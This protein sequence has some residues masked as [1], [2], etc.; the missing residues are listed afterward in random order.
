MKHLKH[1]E[2]WKEHFGNRTRL[3]P[4]VLFS[5]N[6]FV[7]SVIRCVCSQPEFQAIYDLMKANNRR[8]ILHK[9][10]RINIQVISVIYIYKKNISVDCKSQKSNASAWGLM[11][12]PKTFF[13]FLLLALFCL[14]FFLCFLF[15][16][17]FLLF[18][19]LL[20]VCLFVWVFWGCFSDFGGLSHIRQGL[21]WLI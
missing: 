17:L 8:L 11:S 20:L 4:R 3:Q 13:F 14:F 5:L 9:S 15:I 10:F 7:A 18:F 12:T 2:S 19:I 21:Q 6:I 1:G 16:C